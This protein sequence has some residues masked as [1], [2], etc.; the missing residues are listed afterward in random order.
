MAEHDESMRGLHAVQATGGVAHSGRPFVTI[1]ARVHE[2]IVV[3][4]QVGTDEVRRIAH[5]WIEVAESADQD[6]ATLAVTRALG[7]P[8]K[9][10]SLVVQEMRT[11]RQRD[12]A[13]QPPIMV[14]VQ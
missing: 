7:L 3:V 14:V 2:G 4:A 1:T 6:A 11:A 12:E 8:D 10:A 9:L 5:D 13:Q